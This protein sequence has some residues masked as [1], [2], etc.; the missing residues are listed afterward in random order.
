MNLKPITEFFVQIFRILHSLTPGASYGITIIIFTVLIKIL[1]LP[2]NIMQT[3]STIKMQAVQPKLLEIQKKYKNDP[4]KLQEAQVKLY[5][6]EGA[7]PLSGCLPLLIQMPILIAVYQVFQVKDIF[8]GSNAAAQFLWIP[9]IALKD[10]YYILPVLSGLSTYVS[11]LMLTPKN[12]DSKDKN[13]NPMASNTTNLMMSIFF[14]FISWS[15][16]A[17]LV[18]YWVITNVIQLAIQYVL[19]KVMAKKLAPA[20]GK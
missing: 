5:K 1:L 15:L 7:N 6:E 17:G 13:N 18:W 4:Q 16:P 11:T 3:K 12:K 9:N 14:V 20:T 2:L 10:P 19:N 8:A